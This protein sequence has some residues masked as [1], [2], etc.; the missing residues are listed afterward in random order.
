MSPAIHSLWEAYRGAGGG[1]IAMEALVN[2]GQTLLLS[3]YF[4]ESRKIANMLFQHPLPLQSALPLYGGY[5]LASAHL[6]DAIGVDWA[7]S[8]VRRL[9]RARDHAR[10][11]AAALMECAGALDHM[12]R[13]GPGG[14]MRRRAEAMAQ[15]HG[16]HDLTFSEGLAALS[17]SIAARQ[18]LGQEAAQATREIRDIA[19]PDVHD[20]HRGLLS[21]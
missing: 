14:V 2:L 12:G 7:C 19:I 4:L 17:G 8:Q 13:T 1:T 20:L 16:F 6:D 18:P 15:S 11:V 3:G 9:A 10:E 21:V 5:A